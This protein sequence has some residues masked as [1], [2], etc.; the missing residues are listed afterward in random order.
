MIG[1]LHFQK[2]M[3]K[4][5]TLKAEDILRNIKLLVNNNFHLSL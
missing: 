2:M 1:N 3:V 4:K 5:T